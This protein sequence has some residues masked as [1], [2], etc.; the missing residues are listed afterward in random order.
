MATP[1]NAAG[2]KPPRF[3]A[4]SERATE[5]ADIV[6]ENAKTI[7]TSFRM[8]PE[9]HRSL[10]MLCLDDRTTIQSL[11]EEGVKLVMEKRAGRG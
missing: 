11:L 2:V 3:S 9:M 8:T 10:R 6:D 4:R 5:R 7:S 1:R